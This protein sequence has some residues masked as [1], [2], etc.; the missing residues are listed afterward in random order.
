M[1]VAVGGD[2]GIGADPCGVFT[3]AAVSIVSGVGC[4][5]MRGVDGSIWFGPASGA[6]AGSGSISYA[7]FCLKKKNLQ[8]SW[9]A[10]LG[11]GGGFQGADRV[12]SECE[13]VFGDDFGCVV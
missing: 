12:V 3:G 5:T 8:A 13:C 9:V 1:N 7:V 6:G 10:G 4:T 11:C 2:A